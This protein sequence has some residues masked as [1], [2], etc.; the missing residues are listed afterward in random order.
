[1]PGAAPRS[2][3]R[4]PRAAGCRRA[5][6]DAIDVIDAA[7]VQD[8]NALGLEL[9]I[10]VDARDA[11]EQHRRQ[12]QVLQRDCIGED[13]AFDGSTIGICVCCDGSYM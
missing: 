5:S 10:E 9:G 3:R 8:A 6:I 11:V 2:S 13:D 12:R 1:V 4:D 7:D